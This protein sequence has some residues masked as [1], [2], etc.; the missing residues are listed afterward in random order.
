[1]PEF[2]ATHDV[3][4]PLVCKNLLAFVACVGN[5]LFSAALA[6]V[7]P[8]PPLAIAK[9]PVVILLAL[10]VSV[11]AEAAR[12]VHVIGAATPPADVNTWV[13]VPAVIGKLKLYVPAAACGLILTTPEVLPRKFK[14]PKAEPVTPKVNAPLATVTFALPL[15][16]VPVAE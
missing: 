11:V 1:M 8:V 12:V 4:V 5:K 6:V 10:V 13:V 9:V 7:A 3:V 15:T 2:P 14:L 16:A